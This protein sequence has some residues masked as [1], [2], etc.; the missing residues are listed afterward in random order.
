MIWNWLGSKGDG[1]AWSRPVTWTTFPLKCLSGSMPSRLIVVITGGVAG[2]KKCSA[3][4]EITA[5]HHLD[6]ADLQPR[7]IGISEMFGA[8][9]TLNCTVTFPGSA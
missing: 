5:F 3:V 2:R 7:W 1:P 9:V 4:L 8:E 6:P